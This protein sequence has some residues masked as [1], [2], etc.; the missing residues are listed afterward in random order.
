MLSAKCCPL[1]DWNWRFAALEETLQEVHPP[2]SVTFIP[3]KHRG[4]SQIFPIMTWKVSRDLDSNKCNSAGILVLFNIAF[5]WNLKV[6]IH[7]WDISRSID[8]FPGTFV[9]G[10][11]LWRCVKMFCITRSKWIYYFLWCMFLS[12]VILMFGRIPSQ[13]ISNS[14]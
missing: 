1:T 4:N 9:Y 12:R 13:L 10:K 11:K 7:I 3:L 8:S 14:N 2:I 5:C 6:K